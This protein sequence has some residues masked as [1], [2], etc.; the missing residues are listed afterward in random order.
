MC[1]RPHACGFPNEVV[2]V[3]HSK[4]APQKFNMDETK[5]IKIAVCTCIGG[6]MNR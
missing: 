3:K 5:L 6:L 4:I 2:H 1:P